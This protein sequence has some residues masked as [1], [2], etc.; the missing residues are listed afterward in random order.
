[1]TE[2]A[3]QQPG[4]RLETDGGWVYC[5]TQEVPELLEA[6]F[7]DVELCGLHLTRE[8][9]LKQYR[10]EFQ[11][12]AG[13]TIDLHARFTT[14]PWDYA[15]GV[16]E[17]PP[18]VATN[19]YHRSWKADGSITIAGQTYSIDTT[20]DGDHSWGTRDTEEYA[21]HTFKMWSFQTADGSSSVSAIRRDNGLC[22][23]FLNVD[24]EVRAI[25]DVQNHARYDELGVQHDMW[26]QIRDVDGRTATASM[27]RMFAVIGH[28]TEGALWGYEGVGT[29]DVEEWGR[30][31]G[32]VSFFW[33]A[34]FTGSELHTRPEIENP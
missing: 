14:L 28:G 19:R 5:F 10:I 23:G 18:W 7:D 12:D 34:R 4:H 11:D 33:P 6:D 3:M 9:P 16:H 24:G 8:E 30:C 29:Y 15:D 13:T 31:T 2:E 26:V 32:I 20:G 27:D 22:F 17:T 21:R 25:E 1:V